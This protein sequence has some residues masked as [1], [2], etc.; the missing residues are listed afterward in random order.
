M[1]RCLES[2]TRK[3]L[4]RCGKASPAEALVWSKRGTGQ[5]GKTDANGSARVMES[6]DTGRPKRA[7]EIRTVNEPCTIVCAGPGYWG[8]SR[9]HG[10][11]GKKAQPS[12]AWEPDM[13]SLV[14][15]LSSMEK[16]QRHSYL[17]CPFWVAAGKVEA[18]TSET[19]TS[20]LRLLAVLSSRRRV[21]VP[22]GA[23]PAATVAVAS[24]GA[25]APPAAGK[26]T[27]L[28]SGGWHA[29]GS[30]LCPSAAAAAGPAVVALAAAAAARSSSRRSRSCAARRPAS[31]RSNSSSLQ[32]QP[33]GVW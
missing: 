16:K 32:G 23:L 18:S 20:W 24:T 1:R 5:V 15:P 28:A 11:A 4:R 8:V 19:S 21:A 25:A 17:M 27:C 2:G 6:S 22:P 29:L 10:R 31:M 12:R 33:E 14:S 3:K 13:P 7:G 26:S 30:W 9:M